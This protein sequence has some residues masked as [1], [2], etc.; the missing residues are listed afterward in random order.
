[1]DDKLRDSLDAF[2][3]A[4]HKG[5]GRSRGPCSLSHTPPHESEALGVHPDQV[6]EARESAKR[7]GVPTEF[8]PNG[9]P[10][11]RSRKH[12]RDYLKAYGF[13]NR[14]GGFGD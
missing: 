7:R 8:L 9:N 3:Q 6:E 14:D 13:I 11:M 5:R 2:Y 4:M 10:I 1:M 12:Q